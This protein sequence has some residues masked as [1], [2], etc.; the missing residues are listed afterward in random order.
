MGPVNSGRQQWHS[1]HREQGLT[2]VV[3]LVDF[4]T[5]N[6][7]TQLLPGSHEIFTGI[8]WMLGGAQ[9]SALPEGGVLLYDS[10]TYHRG[11]A[12]ETEHSRPALVFRYDHVALAPPPG[13]GLVGSVFHTSTATILHTMLTNIASVRSMVKW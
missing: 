6:G 1:D 2:V 13:V 10:R 9:I 12:N 8:P 5:R 11:L 7:G 3:P 4:T